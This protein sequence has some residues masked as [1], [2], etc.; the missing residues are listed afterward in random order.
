MITI[1]IDAASWSQTEGATVASF[2]NG[3]EVPG[4]SR[5]KM[6]WDCEIGL[7]ISTA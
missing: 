6:R 5:I 2:A 3:S 1:A 7:E 4:N